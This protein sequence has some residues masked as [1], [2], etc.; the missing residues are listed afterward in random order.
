MTKLLIHTVLPQN[1]FGREVHKLGREPK[2][3]LLA[4]AHEH[5]FQLI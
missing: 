1:C 4:Q 2:T 5:V 3:E